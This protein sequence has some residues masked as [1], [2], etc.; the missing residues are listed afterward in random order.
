MH[1]LR[2]SIHLYVPVKLIDQYNSELNMLYQ[3]WHRLSA[4][5][6]IRIW[7]IIYQFKVPL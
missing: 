6:F 2:Y 3:F 5:N 7:Q 4:P 1:A